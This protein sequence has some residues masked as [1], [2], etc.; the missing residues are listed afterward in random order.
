MFLEVGRHMLILWHVDLVREVHNKLRI[1]FD[2][3]TLDAQGDGCSEAS[4]KS[5]VLGDVVGDLV[6]WLEAELHGVVELVSGGEE[7]IS[8]APAPWRLNVSAKCMT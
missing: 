1:P 4:E 3:D 5:V 7:R 6:L 2:D 8:L